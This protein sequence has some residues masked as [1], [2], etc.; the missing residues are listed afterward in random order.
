LP[1]N[2]SL[3]FLMP[4]SFSDTSLINGKLPKSSSSWSRANLPTF[5]H[6]IIR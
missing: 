2:S 3:N 1:S 5:L 4:L 6:H